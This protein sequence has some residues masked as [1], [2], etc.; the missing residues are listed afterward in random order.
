MYRLHG[1]TPD[2]EASITVWWS[3]LVEAVPTLHGKEDNGL[4]ILV[5][6]CIWLGRNNRVFE[7][8]ATMSCEVYRFI[9]V[10]FEQWKRAK[11]RGVVGNIDLSSL[12]GLLWRCGRLIACDHL[13]PLDY[14]C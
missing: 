5:A 7:K 8:V 14:S 11:L 10:D 2:A 1:F 13:L 6:R 12:V 9:L 4:I 3:N